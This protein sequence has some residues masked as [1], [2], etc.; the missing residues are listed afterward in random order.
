MKLR[1]SIFLLIAAPFILLSQQD[2]CP[3][4][5]TE[6]QYEDFTTVINQNPKALL[7]SSTSSQ[8]S[9][10][11]AQDASLPQAPALKLPAAEEKASPK[12]SA[13]PKDRLNVA[14][15]R[16]KVRT[17]IKKRKSSFKGRAKRQ[18]RAKKYRGKCPTF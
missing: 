15:G 13:A 5:E 4:M 10:T 1:I 7:V 11:E 8:A 12:P 6:I 17:A 14:P 16:Q 2:W 9:L 3:C 18:K